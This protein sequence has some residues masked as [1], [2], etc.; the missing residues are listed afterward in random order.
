MT[1]L[2]TPALHATIAK[3]CHDLASPIGAICNSLELYDDTTDVAMQRAA[4]DA[5]RTQSQA[6]SALL[7]FFRL[8]LATAADS[9]VSSDEMIALLNEAPL[10]GKATF[11][12]QS[13]PPQLTG[14]QAQLLMLSARMGKEDLPRGGTVT[15]EWQAQGGLTMQAQ[16]THLR[17]H[18]AE[19]TASRQILLDLWAHSMSILDYTLTIEQQEG[20]RLYTI[21]T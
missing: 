17:Q 21:T 20:A 5:V 1:I 14:A 7:R 4:L 9:L 3:L 8:A 16:G 10:R 11:V 15:L 19:P 6:A 12:W 13:I 18:S 2:A